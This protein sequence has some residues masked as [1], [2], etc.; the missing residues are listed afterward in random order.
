MNTAPRHW[1]DLPDAMTVEEAA[2]FL[3]LKP[4]TLYESIRQN[5]IPAF[6]PSPRRIRLSKVALREWFEGK[7]SA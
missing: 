5:L 7:R 3:R 1:D 2:A 6:R 4:A